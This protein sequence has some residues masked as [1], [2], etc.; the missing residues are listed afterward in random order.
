M[1]AL[2]APAHLTIPS[3]PAVPGLGRTRATL[4]FAQDSIAVAGAL[5]RRY[6]RMAA[7][8]AGGGTRLYS[9]L[10]G[11]PGTV[12]A[13]GHEL[14]QQVTTN[15]EV[16]YKYPLTMGLAP[17]GEVTERTAPLRHF[18][19]GLF[20]VNSD[21][22][23]A[24]RRLLMPAFHKKRIESYRDTMVAIAEEELAELRPGRRLDIAAFMRRL[25]LRIAVRTLFGEDTGGDVGRL[26]H[27]LF[28][29][30]STLGSPLSGLLPYDLPGLPYRR[31]LD[32]AGQADRDLRALVASKRAS[33]ADDGSV[34][35][36]LIRARYE[37]GGA[38]D[39]DELLGHIG[40]IYVA[41]HETSATALTWT[42]FLLAQHP[43]AAA[44]LHDELSGVLSG[45]APSVEDLARLPLLERV[46]KES[47]RVLPPV[48]WNARV[49]S[50]PFELGGH[51]L[52]AG[53]EVW[54]SLYHT[55]REPAIFERPQRFEPRRWERID[56]SVYAYSPFSAGPRMCI[57]A[58]FAMMEIRLILATLLQRVR[59]E[60]D[61]SVPVEP[62]GL[63]VNAPA[64]GMPMF[65][66]PQD[67]NFASG[68]G[69]VRGRVH[70]MVNLPV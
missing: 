9:P 52:P 57:G 61:A 53:T 62:R 46:V 24:H 50:R 8:V 48:P 5:F 66:Q 3:P 42:L 12:L 35:S 20:G 45:A 49:T 1:T 34:L 7:L 32:F 31:L 44:E 11:C 26:G 15:H 2:A 16:F 58:T 69:G 14:N 22:H 6:G 51:L 56:P 38:L 10:P 47:M 63:I 60:Y 41:G 33:G 67:R 59:L 13:Y 28:D 54:M 4:R 65:V 70:D 55:H 21:E 68:A 17:Q 37:D 25:T 30:F 40:V 64:H 39:D 19:A 43:R 23:R 29:G 36:S 18:G 27:T